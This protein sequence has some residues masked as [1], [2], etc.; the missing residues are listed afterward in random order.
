[1][2]DS[3]L[4]KGSLVRGIFLQAKQ[5]VVD[6]KRPKVKKALARHLKLAA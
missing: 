3:G 1:M 5:D 2:K 4:S 6:N